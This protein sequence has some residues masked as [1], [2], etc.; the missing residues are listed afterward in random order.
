M[1]RHSGIHHAHLSGPDLVVAEQAFSTCRDK[2]RESCGLFGVY[3]PDR[4]AAELTYFGLYALQHRGQESAGIAVSNSS[5]IMVVKD[6]GLVSQVFNENILL[7]LQGDLA[8]GHVRYSTTGSSLWLN[9]Q[10]VLKK[11]AQGSFAIAHNG[12][13]VNARQLKEELSR[14]H[15]PFVTSSDT[16]VI[17]CLIATY[18]DQTMESSL[19][20]A[21]ARLAGAYSL[22]ILTE[23]KLIGIRDANGFRPLC[24]GE[25][26]NGYVLASES[27]AID[28]VGGHLVR[29]IEPGEMIVIDKDGVRSQMLLSVQR[30]ALCIFEFIYFARP[31]SII[32]DR[33]LYSIRHRMGT[34]LAEE[35]PAEG[36]LV[37]PIPESGFPAA[38]G[39]AQASGIPFGLGLIKNKY[40]GRTFI[41]PSHAARKIGIALKLNPLRDSLKDKR[42]V[43]VD[44]SIVRGNTS[45]SIIQLLHEAGAREVHMRVSSP[46]IRYPCFFGIDM[47]EREEFIAN[48]RSVEDI[49]K[50]LGVDTLSYL[51]YEGLIRST[52]LSREHFCLAC[53]DEDYPIEIPDRDELDKY[54]L[55]RDWGKTGG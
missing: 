37:V 5:E 21:I 13:L 46:P 44:D 49:R 39:Y 11:F 34:I 35:S 38:I 53:L 25:V 47:A 40:I 23:D 52:G 31:D 32:Y 28:V 3:A 45:Q 41:Q 54:L 42:V 9:A 15:I 43:V 27:C 2:P 19:N 10:P 26:E 8:I 1:G 6:M 48:N 36:D 50:F 24:L 29:E 22:L 55:E 33:S 20:H 14:D 30:K 7:S 18:S 17:A 12:N 51:S 16:E 4:R